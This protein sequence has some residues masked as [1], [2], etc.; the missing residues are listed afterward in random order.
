M[1]PDVSRSGVQ[2]T[3]SSN[4]PV[5]GYQIPDIT[6]CDPK[7]RRLKV[8]TIGAGI[9]GIMMAY[10]IQKQCQNVEHVIYER[11]PD[12][13]GTWYGNRYPGA[14]CDTPSHGYTLNFAL[15]P[16]WPL[17]ASKATD[18]WKYLNKVCEAFDLK[19]YMNFNTEIVGCF[20]DEESG[21][22][23]VKVKQTSE[24]GEKI[25]EETCDVLLHAAGLLSN[26]KWPDIKGIEKFKGKLIRELSISWIFVHAYSLEQDSAKWPKDYQEE[27]WQNESVAILGSGA[28][29]IQL[30]PTIQPHVKHIDVYVRT[31]VWFISVAENDGYAREYTAEEREKF[32]NDTAALVKHAKEVESEINS[33]WEI[34]LKD[35][36]AQERT[37][38]KF[39]ARMEDLIKDK[40]LL[41][42]FTPN[43]SVGCRRLTPGD[44]YMKAIQEPNVDVHFAAVEEMTEDSVIDSE[45]QERKVDTVICATGFDVS[46][47][48]RFPIIGQNGV[49][50]REKWKEIP[51]SYLG[52]AVP[53]IPNFLTFMGPTWPIQNGSVIGSLGGVANY[54]IKFIKKIQNEFIKSIAPKQDVTD[55][56]NSH[57]QEFMKKS[58]WSSDC[59]TWY[60]NNETGRVNAIFPGGS[61]H[62]LEV[63]E[64]PR[65]EDYNITYQNKHNPWAYLGLGFTIRDRTEGADI[66]PYINEEAIDPRW[67]ELIKSG[68][69]IL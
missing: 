30:L 61:L 57:T 7:N 20:W 53:D 9:S 54:A 56:F 6:F 29:S 19:K 58:V 13:G 27:Q 11:N 45:G 33:L 5:D 14:A 49:D 48:P 31:A 59:R 41:K 62:Y 44:P 55:L 34:F 46:Y 32:R 35:S 43:F 3:A 65:Y 15:N 8:L 24:S 42:G 25:F 51:E 63:I 68:V 64:N 26:F 39:L 67:L 38:K 60:K 66:A 69:A 12:I 47:I 22:W 52:L 37:K 28:S 21:K 23:T 50:L 1:A 17:Y 36:D 18:I 16:D 4:M 10:H 40:R 2:S